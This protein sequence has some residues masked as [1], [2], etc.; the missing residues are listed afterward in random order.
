MEKALIILFLVL[1]AGRFCWRYVLQQLNIRNLQKHGKEIP[2]VFQGVIDEGT[3]TKMVDY[4]V[5]NTRLAA[6]ENLVDDLVELA[7]VFLFL[8]FFVSLITAW[9]DPLYRTGADI[10]RS[11]CRNCR[12]LRNPL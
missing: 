4:T 1:F 11:V 7:L 6:K 3:L 5:D 2:P 8:P 12:G 9:K 10:F